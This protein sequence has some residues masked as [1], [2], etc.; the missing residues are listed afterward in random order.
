MRRRDF[1]ALDAFNGWYSARQSTTAVRSSICAFFHFGLEFCSPFCCRL[2]T[3][4]LCREAHL[5]LRAS[6]RLIYYHCPA[7]QHRRSDEVLYLHISTSQ[8]SSRVARREG[9]FP[10]VMISPQRLRLS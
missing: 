1:C 5:N 9:K 7:Q 10:L 6:S 4:C 8:E 2:F 3:G